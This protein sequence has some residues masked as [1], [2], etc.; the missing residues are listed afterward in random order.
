LT[1]VAPEYVFAAVVRERV[2]APSFVNPPAPD[3]APVNVK[4][5][6]PLVVVVLLTVTITESLSVVVAEIV[7][8]T[9]PVPPTVIAADPELT[10]NVNEPPVPLDSKKVFVELLVSAIEPTVRAPLRVTV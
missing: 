5:P 9:S 4:A 8:T 7:F 6:E 10:S 2:P 1:D 3:Q